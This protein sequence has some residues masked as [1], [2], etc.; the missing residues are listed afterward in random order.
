MPR[1]PTDRLLLTIAVACAALASSAQAQTPGSAL[2]IGTDGHG[3]RIVEQGRPGR[4]VVLLS[5]QRYRK[6]AGNR[7]LLFCA[8]VPRVSLG[9][10]TFPHPRHHVPD[11]S[12][13]RRGAIAVL[14]PPR[15]RGPIPT[16][17]S[18]RW[19]WCTLSVSNVRRMSFAT[20]PLTAAG[21]AFADERQVASRVIASELLLTWRPARVERVLRRMHAVALS[22]PA[23]LPPAGRLGFYRDGQKHVYAAQIDR[24]GDL[25]FLERDGDVV[26]TNLLR[27]LQDPLLLW[28]ADPFT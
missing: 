28:G 22:S 27:Y 26:R 12:R 9:G 15:R 8:R 6:V 24:A 7:L 19:D 2:P 3:T 25:L 14:N 5:A 10:G 16:R 17:L 4:L 18:P 1:R 21:A 11:P 23:E 20:V 13:L